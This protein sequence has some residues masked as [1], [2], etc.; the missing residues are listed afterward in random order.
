M[1]VVSFFSG[2]LLATPFCDKI[3][4]ISSS[5]YC[6]AYYWSFNEFEIMVDIIFLWDT[7]YMLAL[8]ELTFSLYWTLRYSPNWV[9]IIAKTFSNVTF[10][11]YLTTALL[12]TTQSFLPVSSP[13]SLTIS[14]ALMTLISASPICST[15]DTLLSCV[16]SLLFIFSTFSLRW[17]RSAFTAWHSARATSSCIRAS[18]KS[19][20]TSLSYPFSWKFSDLT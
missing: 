20:F 14:R 13:C 16:Y 11:S 7:L 19:R 2:K 1:T 17:S 4:W 5:F 3:F 15:S 10:L 18:F 12:G 9:C 6:S 8:R